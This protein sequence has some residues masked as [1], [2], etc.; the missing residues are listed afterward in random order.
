[1]QIA[2][3]MRVFKQDNR[4]PGQI[5]QC[6]SHGPDS[7]VYMPADLFMSAFNGPP[8]FGFI[9]PTPKYLLPIVVHHACITHLSDLIIRYLPTHDLLDLCIACITDVLNV[10]YIIDFSR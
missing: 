9:G 8:F 2:T 4:A 5:Y 1:M 6:I 7:D 3:R 10:F